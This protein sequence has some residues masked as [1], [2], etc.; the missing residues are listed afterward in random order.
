MTNETMT[1]ISAL[2]AITAV[3]VRMSF[4]DN[5]VLD[6]VDVTVER[7]SVFALLGPNGAGKTTMVR[8]LATLLEPDHGEIRVAGH[9]VAREPDAVRDAIGVTGQFSAVDDL[10]T[11][12]ENLALMADLHHLKRADARRRISD[13]LERF[14]LVQA[15]DRMV[16]TYSGGDAPA[17]RSGD[18]ADGQAAGHLPRRADYRP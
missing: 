5:V 2:H 17:T 11:G 1:D 16:A 8:I 4:G 18:D 6:G 10:L 12:R 13:L 7:G 14:E 9:D 3:D 15:A